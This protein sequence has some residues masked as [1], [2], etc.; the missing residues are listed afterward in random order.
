MKHM[1]RML[2]KFGMTFC[3]GMLLLSSSIYATE[4][5]QKDV[6]SYV[7]TDE[8]SVYYAQ[9]SEHVISVLSK[10]EAFILEERGEEYS[11]V[12]LDNGLS[13][14]IPTETIADEKT[15]STVE[16]SASRGGGRSG[17]GGSEAESGKSSKRDKLLKYANSLL[18]CRYSYGSRGPKRFD[19][20]GF[21]GYSY[22]K[23]LGIKLPRD[24]RSMSKVGKKVKKSELMKGDLVFFN[25][26]GGSRI[27]HVGMYIGDGKFIH[28]SSGTVRKVTISN[29][30]SGYYSKRYNTARRILK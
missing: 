17:E 3:T 28:A 7:N 18:G 1:G 13:G 30:S 27:T 12:L 21:V 8:V 5:A 10:G 14:Y 4:A 16:E 23:A 6:A 20:S 22:E 26:A 2:R 19:C 9:G 11:K 25:T 29:L 24:S 15:E